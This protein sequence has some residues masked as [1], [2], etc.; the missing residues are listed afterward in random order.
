MNGKQS[1]HTFPEAAREHK[2]T[3]AV[4]LFLGYPFLG[5]DKRTHGRNPGRA[6]ASAPR[7]Q[8]ATS[9]KWIAVHDASHFL[10]RFLFADPQRLL[11]ARTRPIASQSCAKFSGGVPALAGPFDRI[12]RN[13]GQRPGSSRTGWSCSPRRAASMA[14]G[15]RVKSA[16]RDVGLP[17]QS[18]CPKGTK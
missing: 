15:T 3:R 10:S 7:Y 11:Y 4:P 12:P 14:S 17:R 16:T 5:M 18:S 2:N 6:S 8:T 9:I 1:S 13:A